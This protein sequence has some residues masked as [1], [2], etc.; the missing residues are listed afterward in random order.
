[1]A[2]N[3]VTATATSVEILEALAHLGNA[4]VTEIAT[5]IDG[6]KSNVHKHIKTLEDANFVKKRDGTYRIGNR[7]LEFAN[8]AK[9]REPIYHEAI[10]NLAKLADVTGAT[11]IL[12][13]REGNEGV[14]LHTIS[15]AKQVDAE[16]LDGERAPLHELPGGLAILSCYSPDERRSFLEQTTDTGQ[17]IAPILER[18]VEIEQQS[19][20]VSKSEDGTGLE[21]I[22]APITKNGTPQGAI[23]IQQPMAENERNRIETDLQKLIRN[24]AYTIS[25]RLTEQ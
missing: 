12:V 13:V 9:Q 19:V 5:A 17:D 3:R 7:F 1:M 22:V 6:S 21:E 15:P 23:G 24:T 10:N 4:G 2:T 8:A 11:A 14:Y 20:V 18:L 25:N 16:L